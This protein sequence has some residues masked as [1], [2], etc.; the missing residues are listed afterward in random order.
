MK[1]K[2]EECIFC[3]IV[4]KEIP[5]EI[6]YE[7]KE[8]LVFKDINPEAPIHL[9]AIPKKHIKSL[10]EVEKDD[11]ELMG[12][13]IMIINKVAKEQGIA[14]KGFRV[15]TNCGEDAGQLVKHLHFHI[16]GGKK[17]GSKIVSCES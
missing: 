9:L 1:L 17:L 10:I 13:I 7:D 5:S 16:I 8:I 6:I 12:K 15:I 3:K 11:I 14:E 2:M 4:N